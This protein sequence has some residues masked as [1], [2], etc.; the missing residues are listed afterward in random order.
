MGLDLILYRKDKPLS[1]MTFEELERAELAYGRKTWA[2]ADFF[3]NRCEAI[4]G[5]WEY[6][7]I[8]QDWDEFIDSVSDLG[9]PEFRTKVD[10]LVDTLIDR[11]YFGEDESEEIQELH[12]ELEDW[13][14]GALGADGWY[15]LGL[16]WEL[17]AV[18]RWYEADAEVQKA[19][20]E[21]KELILIKSY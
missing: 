5:D 7:V 15:Q 3:H 14:D 1:Q 12:K 20:K 17:A 11:D 10:T 18:C 4:D 8:K 2:I 21:G 16:A 13:L 9:N 6:K 19:F